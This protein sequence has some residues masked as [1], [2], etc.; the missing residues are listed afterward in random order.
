M[1]KINGE[2]GVNPLQVL[3]KYGLYQSDQIFFLAL[4]EITPNPAQP[5]KYFDPLDLKELADS[6]IRYGI[7]QPLTVRRSKWGYELVAGERRLRA[8]SLAGLRKAPCIVI[9]VDKEESSIIA[10]VENLQRRDLDYIEEAE[11][12]SKLIQTFDMS[13]EEAARRVGKTQSAVANKLRILKL[14]RD[15][16]ERLK[17]K[18]LTERHARALL[19]LGSNQERC[20]VLEYVIAQ[21]LNVAKTEAYIDQYLNALNQP[22]AKE[23]SPRALARPI[24]VIKDVR[25][26]LNTLHRNISMLND[27]GMKTHIE[28]GGTDT[29]AIITIKIA[30]AERPSH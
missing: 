26:F 15:M 21:E 27:S 5:R 19:R 3:Q 28:Q 17:Q 10:L 4:D 6:I 9:D 23:S 18:G 8:A 7:L 2:N 16:L 14:P 11:G 24:Y 20:E 1:C 30:K 25:F 22:A 29:E 13:Q 12:L